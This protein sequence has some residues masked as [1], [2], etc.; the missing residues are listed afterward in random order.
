MW[1]LLNPKALSCVEVCWIVLGSNSQL[2]PGC[3][4]SIATTWL[5]VPSYR[6]GSWCGMCKPCWTLELI[7]SAEQPGRMLSRSTALPSI[8]KV[9]AQDG[10]THVP[11][12][13]CVC[14]L[15]FGFAEA[16]YAQDQR[17]L[18]LC[19]ENGLIVWEEVLGWQ[20]T[21]RARRST[22]FMPALS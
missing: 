22:L 6:T 9:W 17:F 8:M 2:D 3:S 13:P 15:L 19:D 21:P 18:D 1:K 10:A 14:S 4:A 16:H 11:T 5:P 12:W 20:N 7:L